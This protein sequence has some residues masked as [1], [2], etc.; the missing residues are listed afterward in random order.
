MQVRH[1]CSFLAADDHGEC[2]RLHVFVDILDAPTLQDPHA[3]KEGPLRI[4][5]DNGWD[6]V[7]IEKGVYEVAAIRVP[8]R[9]D[10]PLAP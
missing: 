8:L 4:A 1:K 9:S 7:R 5:T 3:E 6:V 2:H 10:D